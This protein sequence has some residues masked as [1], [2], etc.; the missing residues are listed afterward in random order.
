MEKFQEVENIETLIEALNYDEREL[1]NWHG[2]VGS[3]NL[4]NDALVISS[5]WADP[6]AGTNQQ[7]LVIKV[8]SIKKREQIV[9]SGYDD[10][11]DINVECP[12]WLTPT[13]FV[14]R[15]LGAISEGTKTPAGLVPKIRGEKMDKERGGLVADF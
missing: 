14:E 5:S 7:K 1:P 11:R 15:M 2:Q 13:L 10:V 6:R 4:V 8:E 3:C 9:I 12:E